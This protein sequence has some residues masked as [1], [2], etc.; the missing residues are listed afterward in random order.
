MRPRDTQRSRVY[1]AD[2]AIATWTQEISNNELQAFVDNALDK[3]AI[4]ARWGARKVY[5]ELG[6]GGAHANYNRISLGVQTRNPHIICHELAHSLTSNKYAAHGP[7]Y[8]GVYLFIANVI[9]GPEFAK[10]LRA[11][12]KAKKVKV[13]RKGIP[14]IAERV[15]ESRSAVERLARQQAKTAAVNTITKLIASGAI[16]KAEAKRVIDSA[17]R[18]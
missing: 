3:R 6:R 1:E 8:C 16:S 14:P 4:R 7:E 11:A 17:T 18:R 5:V 10:Q 15:T 13:N 12:F 2:R 9:I